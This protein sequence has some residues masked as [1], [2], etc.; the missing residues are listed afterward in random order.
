MS[1]LIALITDHRTEMAFVRELNRFDSEPRSKNPIKCSRRATALKMS[2][3]A[4]ARFLIRPRRDLSSNDVT[5]PTQSKFATLNVAF[6]LL[7]VFRFRP[8]RDDHKRS[9]ITACIAFFDHGRDLIV[10]ERNLGD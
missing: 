6:H 4:T 3:H 2:E 1:N 8:F 5:D 7:P 10:V 9:V